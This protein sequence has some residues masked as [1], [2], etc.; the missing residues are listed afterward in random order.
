MKRQAGFTLIELLVAL[1]V[2][3]IAALAL[4]HLSGQNARSA[5]LIK[6]RTLAAIVAEN[7]AVEA[8]LSVLAVG[9]EQGEEQAGGRTWRWVRRTTET[10]DAGL[11]RVDIAVRG[12]GDEQVL[13]SLSLFKVR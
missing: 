12:E 10:A 7:R 11:V 1:A 2:F 13:A 9:E 6:T 8:Q 4:L 5:D 3:S